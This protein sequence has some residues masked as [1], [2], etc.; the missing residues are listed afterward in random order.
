[1][2]QLTPLVQRKIKNSIFGNK[3][4]RKFNKLLERKTCD[5]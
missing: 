1:M 5:S 2:L 4:A 3:G